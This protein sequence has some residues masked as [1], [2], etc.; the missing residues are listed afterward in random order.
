[1]DRSDVLGNVLTRSWDGANIVRNNPRMVT[2]L[3]VPTEVHVASVTCVATDTNLAYVTYR[4]LERLDD[5]QSGAV[6]ISQSLAEHCEN[7]SSQ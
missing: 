2:E 3:H 1:M 6:G 5:V 4:T 7:V